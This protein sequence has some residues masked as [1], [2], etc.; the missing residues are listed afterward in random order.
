MMDLFGIRI[1]FCQWLEEQCGC[2]GV[3]LK[4]GFCS[5]VSVLSL[6]NELPQTLGFKTAC[7]YYLLV[8]TGQEFG[9]R[10]SWVFCSE[11]HHAEI[12]VLSRAVVSSEFFFFFFFLRFI[13]FIFWL[14]WVFVAAWG[15]SLV[16]ASRAYFLLQC[17][18][19]SFWW[20]LVAER[21][22]VVISSRLSSCG[23]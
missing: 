22:S 23:L 17:P 2:V 3:C 13:Y 8:S 16:V 6:H 9:A 12:K 21:S 20:L 10:V 19:F 18:G 7:I 14:Y 11:F 15:L 4:S 5:C 1:L